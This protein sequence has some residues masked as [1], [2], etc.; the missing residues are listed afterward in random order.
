MLKLN[1]EE[2]EQTVNADELHK[3]KGSL[4]S[5]AP[6]KALGR[7]L[8]GVHYSKEKIDVIWS[9]WPSV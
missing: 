4:A 6:R 3:R 9:D 1:I 8:G 7:W 5:R 2:I